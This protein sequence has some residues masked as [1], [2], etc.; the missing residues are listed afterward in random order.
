[1]TFRMVWRQGMIAQS[2]D[3]SCL[4]VA[5]RLAHSDPKNCSFLVTSSNPQFTVPR[6]CSPDKVGS[7]QTRS[8]LTYGCLQRPEFKS[9]HCSIPA[10][11][12]DPEVV[13]LSR[14]LDKRLGVLRGPGPFWAATGILDLLRM[15]PGGSITATTGRDSEPLLFRVVSPALSGCGRAYGTSD[16]HSA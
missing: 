9:A 8:Q 14:L 1:M 11:S 10:V 16:L 3:L 4:S 12:P 13:K 2:G 5:N 7:S 6:K 15:L